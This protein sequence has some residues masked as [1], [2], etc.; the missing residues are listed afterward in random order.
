[1]T[2]TRKIYTKADEQLSRM[3]SGLMRS[4]DN[5]CIMVAIPVR[6][7]IAL[8]QECV[9]TVIAGMAPW[10]LLCVYDDLSDQF[11]PADYLFIDHPNKNLVHAPFG[12]P[13]IRPEYDEGGKSIGI[14]AQRRNHFMEFSRRVAAGEPL[15]HLYLTDADAPHDPL[16]RRTLLNLQKSCDGAPVCGYNTD[17]HAKLEGNTLEDDTR[18][19]EVFLCGQMPVSPV[20]WR[21]FAP[22]V[23][24]LLTREHVAKVCAALPD[25][26]E[27]WD[28][29]WT[30]PT[31]LGNRFAIARQSVVS[32]IGYGGYHHPADAGWEG[33]DVPLNPTPWLVQK[34]AEIIARLKAKQS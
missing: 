3:H 22:G 31:I 9:P 33:G 28:W 11:D 5:N 12:G 20:I 29:D 17:A 32:H 10:D 4:E 15:T 7:R 24:Y 19:E 1:M 25:L 6:N 34:R 18:T 8:M 14:E 16:W 2:T 26:P 23:S 30:V 27:H 13:K 21:R